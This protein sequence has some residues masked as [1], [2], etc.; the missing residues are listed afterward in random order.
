LNDNDKTV[1]DQA[2]RVLNTLGMLDE[3]RTDAL[4]AVLPS[5]AKKNFSS[6]FSK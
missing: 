6:K 3:T 4:I 1:R 5:N 2:M